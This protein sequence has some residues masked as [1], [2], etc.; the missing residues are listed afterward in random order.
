MIRIRMVGAGRHLRAGQQLPGETSRSPDQAPSR[1]QF[2]ATRSQAWIRTLA[3]PPGSAIRRG[4]PRV[5]VL[6]SRLQEFLR[7]R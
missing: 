1:L 5:A 4:F 7:M 3:A 2:S 6:P